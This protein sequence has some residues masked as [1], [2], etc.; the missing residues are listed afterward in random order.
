MK[1]AW[2]GGPPMRRAPFVIISKKATLS[3]HASAWIKSSGLY[4]TKKKL[5]VRS[6]FEESSLPN[7]MKKAWSGGPPMRRAPFVIIS[8]KAV[9]SVLTLS[10]ILKGY[11]CVQQN[12][13]F[14]IQLSSY[15][16]TRNTKLSFLHL[17]YRN[18]SNMSSCWKGW[19]FSINMTSMSTNPFPKT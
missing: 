6:F 3:S 11:R 1:K 18:C 4:N 17:E 7:N 14:Y 10:Y 12:T 2:S 16:N 8:K 15:V 19:R 9:D 13:Y 5:E